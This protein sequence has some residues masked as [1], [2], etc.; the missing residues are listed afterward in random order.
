VT[1]GR[2]QRVEVLDVEGADHEDGAWV[3]GP[4]A[5]GEE[6]D[7]CVSAVHDVVLVADVGGPAGD[8]SAERAPVAGWLTRDHGRCHLSSRPGSGG[9]GP[10]RE[11]MD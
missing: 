9:R 6:S 11:E 10:R 8:Q 5:R 2:R 7:R 3:A 1:D 4:P